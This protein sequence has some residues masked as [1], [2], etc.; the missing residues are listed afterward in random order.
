[1]SKRVNYLSVIPRDAKE[2]DAFYLKPVSKF[3]AETS[4]PWFTKS[5]IDKNWLSEML[6]EMCREEMCI[7]GNFTNHSLRTFGATTLFQV[8]CNE[9]LIQQRTWHR[10]VDALRQYEC[11]SHSQLL[12]VSNIMFGA[13]STKK[14]EIVSLREKSTEKKEF[15]S[16]KVNEK[17][18]PMS[19]P[20]PTIVLSRCTFTGC[21]INFTGGAVGETKCEITEEK[22]YTEEFKVLEGLDFNDIF[23]DSA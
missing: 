23:E 3:S 5:S 8:G 4:S 7:G 17:A 2:N 10:S 19:N 13:K 15:L 6:K 16:S 1:M 12:G 18:S 21:S 9:K 11:T 22:H 14:K 20:S